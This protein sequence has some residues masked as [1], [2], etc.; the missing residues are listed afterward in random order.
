MVDVI[1]LGLNRYGERVYDWLVDRDDA[2][3]MCVVTDESQYSTIRELTPDLLVS[4]GFKYI[5]PEDI[6]KIP[7]L[8]A[9][10]LHHSYLPYNRGYNPDVWSIIEG[11]PAGV[12]VHYMTPDVDAGDIIDRRNVEIKPD[13]TS[14]SLYER[15]E[16][17]QVDIFQENW[18]DIKSGTTKTITQD[19]NEGT[20]HYKSDFVDLWELDESED[21][22]IGEF[23]D[24]L[25]ALTH[26]PYNN[27]YFE[28]EGEKFYID[29]KITPE[30][31]VDSSDSIHWNISDYSEAE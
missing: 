26:P 19:E 22:K 15:L 7:E 31:E 12:S 18:D 10:N 2:N 9:I 11:T 1:L 13:D 28:R 24:R 25:R 14:K 3:V 21:I 27:V 30:S 20:F 29:I 8:G 23:I 5:V 6:L 17:H 16:K 4:A